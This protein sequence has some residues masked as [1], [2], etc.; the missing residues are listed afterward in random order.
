[1]RLS[2]A[3]QHVEGY[4][5]GAD[6][7]FARVSTDTRTLQRGDLYIALRGA[8]YD[9]HDFV[10]AAA[11]QGAVAALVERPVEVS[12]PLLT[13]ADTRL[14]LGRLGAAWRAQFEIP[15]IAVT[16]SNGKTTVKEMV[17]AIL[18]ME[19]VVLATD[20]NLNNDIG[21]PLMLLRLGS[22]HHAAV[23][24]MG[25]NH[26]GEIAY[27]STLARPTVA[28]VNN[29][30]PAHLE[31][32]GSIDEV[33]RTKGGIYS[34][35]APGG[36]AILNVDDVYH[37]LWREMAR[38]RRTLTFGHAAQ[39]DIRATDIHSDTLGRPHFTLI[40]PQ[41]STPIALPLLGAHNV[42][43][44]LAAAAAAH[45][46]DVPLAVIRAGLE[47]MTPVKGRMQPK[48]GR[49]GIAII[50]DT[51][52]ANPRSVEAAVATLAQLPGY[53]MAVLGDMGELGSTGTQLHAAL[54]SYIKEAGIDTLYTLGPLSAQ[55]AQTFG[56][57]ARNYTE[58]SALNEALRTA[59][60][61]HS[62]RPLTVLVKGS[63][64]MQM[65]R[66]VAALVEEKH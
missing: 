11:S 55:A 18:G 62:E 41:G 33:A 9:A 34:G 12:I 16:G 31:G 42:S 25:A 45:T 57:M 37:T 60:M 65:E 44:A 66:V 23:I 20:G 38:P 21:V 5:Q 2:V 47:K 46:V 6:A 19:G 22:A 61:Q 59:L 4:L 58:H 32:F 63:R 39:A 56:P 43:N 54:G 53:K 27:L 35:L 7:D 14:A 40:T 50:D 24:E 26:P 51:Y 8:K 13:V 17:A 1:M 15:L 64:Y 28:L 36:T 3:A 48:P 49:D 29:A 10:A 30:G 52:N